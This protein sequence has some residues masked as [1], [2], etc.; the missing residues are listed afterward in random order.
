MSDVVT[1]YLG[2]FEDFE[3][4][5][6]LEILRDHDIHATSKHDT[7]END[8][9]AYPSMFSDRGVI[10]VDAA[11]LD[12]AKAILAEELPQH[13]ASIQAAMEELANADV[14]PEPDGD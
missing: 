1:T 7:T 10:L 14:E 13:L 9:S 4:E 6:V 2:T 12:E 11:R 8:H 3:E 5:L